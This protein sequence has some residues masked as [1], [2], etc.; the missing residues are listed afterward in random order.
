ML[1]KGVQ[2]SAGKSR[3]REGVQQENGQ[4]NGSQRVA[5][6]HYSLLSLEHGSCPK[7]TLMLDEH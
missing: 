1:S 6:S 2:N 3:A 5:S 7:L 4:D